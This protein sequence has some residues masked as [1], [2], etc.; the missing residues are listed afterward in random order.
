MAIV[1]ALTE[2]KEDVRN[3]RDSDTHRCPAVENE[4]DKCDC[5]FYDAVMDKIQK[6]IDAYKLILGD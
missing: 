5:G 3:L 6:L 4:D 2:I 1:E